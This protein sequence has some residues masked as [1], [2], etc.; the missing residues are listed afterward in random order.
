[1][2]KLLASILSVA[3]I[4]SML[5]CVSA[6]AAAKP[7]TLKVAFAEA[8]TDLKAQAFEEFKKAVEERTEG[9]IVI[10]LYP[11]N[12]LGSLPDALE[13]VALGGNIIVSTSVDTLADYGTPNWIAPTIF[14]ALSSA[15]EVLA[16]QDSELYKEMCA[17]IEENGIKLLCMNYVATPRQLLSVKPVKTFED[18]SKLK[19]RV[20]TATFGAF[21]EA[22]GAST[23]STAWSEVY[24]SLSTGVLDAAE[25]PLGTLY[26]SSL[27]EVA[28]YITL[29][30]HC[31]SPAGMV[32]SNNIFKALGDEYS[33]I[34]QEEAINAGEWY[35]SACAAAG[36]DFRAKLEAEGVTFIE[37]SPEDMQKMK[38][39]SVVVYD[40][41]PEM[42]PDIYDQIQAAIAG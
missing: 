27:Y 40:N 7:V 15:D 13:Q 30:S 5:F 25:A 22:A 18:I 42:S 3:L 20:P 24:T 1:M 16:F 9:N 31:L 21:F 8:A 29:T 6:S 19:V 36:D 38:E 41:F 35:T 17:T 11:N 39:T 12:E 14:Y 2:K 32:M 4:L 10:E 23:I 26:N 34:L 33:A 28:K 37:F